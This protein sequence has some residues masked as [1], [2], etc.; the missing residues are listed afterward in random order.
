MQGTAKQLFK[1]P[2]RQEAIN[3]AISLAKKSDI[4]VLT[5]KGH[6]KSLCRGKIEHPWSDHAGI[7]EALK[8]LK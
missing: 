4:V 3:Q 2:N 8:K 6:E 5:G 7:Q 1:I